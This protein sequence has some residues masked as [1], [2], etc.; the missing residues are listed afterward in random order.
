METYLLQNM[1]QVVTLLWMSGE[2][3]ENTK[4]IQEEVRMEKEKK[5]SK[6]K[7]ALIIAGGIALTVAG[8]IV[9]PPLLDKYA[10]KAYKSSLK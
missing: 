2:V 4:T 8:F 9:I 10:N 5:K 3:A 1:C 6:G 7:K